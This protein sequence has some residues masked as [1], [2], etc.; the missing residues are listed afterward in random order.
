[1]THGGNGYGAV[2]RSALAGGDGMIPQTF[3]VR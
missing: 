1:M 2:V 3:I